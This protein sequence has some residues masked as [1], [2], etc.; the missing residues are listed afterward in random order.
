LEAEHLAVALTRLRYDLRQYHASVR[1]QLMM[2]RQLQKETKG[3][4][5]ALRTESNAPLASFQELRL[6]L[7]ETERKRYASELK[8][9]L[10]EHEKQSERLSHLQRFWKWIVR[11]LCDVILM[12]THLAFHRRQ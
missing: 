6:R 7:D 8:A 3:T 5:F 12:F 11:P 1:E 4:A 10:V 9:G 2:F